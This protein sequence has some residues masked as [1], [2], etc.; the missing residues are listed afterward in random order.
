MPE[1]CKFDH[2]TLAELS[3]LILF[4]GF[5]FKFYQSLYSPC[6]LFLRSYLFERE[7]ERKSMGGG[8]QRERNRQTPC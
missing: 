7:R 8:E 6:I 4:L 2:I 1:S 3:F 5:A